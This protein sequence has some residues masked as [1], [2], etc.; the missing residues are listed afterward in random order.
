MNKKK[1]SNKGFGMLL[2]DSPLI[3]LRW[4]ESKKVYSGHIR[5]LGL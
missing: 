3:Y 5:R 4:E 1:E 2:L